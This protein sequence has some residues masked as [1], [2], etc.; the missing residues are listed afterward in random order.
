ML[1]VL[2]PS[3]VSA[4]N[5]YLFQKLKDYF[6]FPMES[7][8]FSYNFYCISL[9]LAR[10]LVLHCMPLRTRQT[11]T[12][13]VWEGIKAAV[14]AGHDI[15]LRAM[16]KLRRHGHRET[17]AL[18]ER[19]IFKKELASYCISVVLTGLLYCFI[20]LPFC[21]FRT[22]VKLLLVRVQHFLMLLLHSKSF[23]NNWIMGDFYSEESVGNK[24]CRVT[25][26][27]TFILF[28]S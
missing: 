2:N 6:F 20:M 12:E 9:K 10:T 5:Q 26:F 16:T 21:R 17:V 11:N 8:L 22:L 24:S 27:V 14:A 18:P 23:R 19:D 4:G 25:C 15:L 1:N 7:F 3:K 28:T 13:A